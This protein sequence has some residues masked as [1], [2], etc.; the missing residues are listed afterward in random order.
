MLIKN[1]FLVFPTASLLAFRV[2]YSL[3]LTKLGE[4]FLFN[5]NSTNNDEEREYQRAPTHSSRLCRVFCS[6]LLK[7]FVRFDYTMRTK[8]TSS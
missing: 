1:L 4:K 3:L 7:I 8:S 5:K 2:R 6:I